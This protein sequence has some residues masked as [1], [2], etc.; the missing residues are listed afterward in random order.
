M[1]LHS[2]CPKVVCTPPSEFVISLG[3]RHSSTSLALMRLCARITASSALP[4]RRQAYC[5]G[6]NSISND[7]SEICDKR[8]RSDL[9]PFVLA[10]IDSGVSTPYELKAAAGLSPGATIPSLRRLLEEELVVQG[11]PWPM[12]PRG[13]QNHSRRPPVPEERLAA[14]FLRQSAVQRLKS[15]GLTEEPDEPAPLPPLALWYRK[16]RCASAE[17][18]LNGEA[19]A[20][21]AMAKAL[22]RRPSGKQRQ[23]RLHPSSKTARKVFQKARTRRVS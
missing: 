9:D 8:R 5:Y 1:Y 13:L 11:K 12:W 7:M 20:A 18:L 2:N 14:G 23:G 19:D 3:R 10:L 4:P 16:L 22:T 21:L 6:C 15:I 17:A